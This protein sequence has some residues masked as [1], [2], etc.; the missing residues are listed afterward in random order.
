MTIDSITEK[1][2]ENSNLIGEFENLFIINSKA[3]FPV[4]TLQAR[5][6]TLFNATISPDLSSL[7]TDSSSFISNCLSFSNSHETASFGL[8]L[9]INFDM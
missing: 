2:N 9:E 6:K 7:G 5:A 4:F 8:H 1:F 3:L